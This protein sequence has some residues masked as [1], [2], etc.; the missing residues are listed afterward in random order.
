MS[1]TLYDSAIPVF[2]QFL[3]ALSVILKKAETHCEAKKIDPEALLG[4]RLF[5]D[6][7]PLRR[8]VQL[9]CDFAKGA[10]ARLAGIPVPSFPDDEK[11]FSELAARI[12]KTLDLLAALKKEQFV[13]AGTRTVTL[14]IGGADMSFTGA[15]YLRHFALGNFYFHLTTAYDILRHNGLEIGKRDFMG[16]I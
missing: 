12:A 14:K 15:I 7:F 1:D 6:M 13:D 9:A 8:Q 3:N 5:P 4:A 11:T 10:G 16:R 2:T